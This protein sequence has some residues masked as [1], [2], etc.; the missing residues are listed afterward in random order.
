MK[1]HILKLLL[2]SWAITTAIPAM[3]KPNFIV[4]FIDDMGY[5]DIG[6]FGS[7][8]NE[9]PHL[10]RMAKE[11]MKLTSFYVAS[12]VCSPSR[13]A[14]MTGSYPKRVGLAKGSGHIVLFPGDPHGLNPKEITI[15]EML[16]EEG[17]ATGCYGKW[18]LGDQPEF[19]PTAQGFDEYYGIPYSNDMWPGLKRWQFPHLPILRGTKVIDQVDDMDEQ[20]ELCRLFTEEAVKFIEKNKDGPF[21]VYLPHAF[22]HGPRKASPE[23]MAKAKTVE[24]A[25]VEEVD[26]SAG[27]ILDAV[28]KAG[29]EKN[30]FVLFTSDNGGAGGL[31][32]A[33]LRGGKGSAWEGGVRE[34]AIAWWPG[35]VPA[36]SVCKEIASTMD[37]LPTFAKWAGGKVPD[38]RVIDGRDVSDLFLGKPGAKTPHDR[39]FYHQADNLR[40]VRS[41]PWKL[42]RNGPLYNLDEDISEKKNVANK[43]PNV[44]KRLKGYMN[45]FENDLKK[46]SRPIGKAKNPRTLVPR[47]GVEG[48]DAYTPTLWIGKTK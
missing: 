29:I 4:I 38:D 21:F 30:T 12:P 20:A 14:L 44:V 13:A 37:L 27:Q 10:D 17:Y 41:G 1:S 40:A 34:P 23:F 45:E 2:A 22:V 36:G 6:P 42:F 35:K 25:Q 5:G 47:P 46:N 24:E 33:P 11:G 31:S 3:A 9:T 32:S 48:E 8:K 39:F 26:W 18:H 16:K 7:T 19:L 15:A 43:H 28:R